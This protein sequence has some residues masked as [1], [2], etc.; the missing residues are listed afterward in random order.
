MNGHGEIA[1]GV[2]L[3]N[4]VREF[5]PHDLGDLLG[6]HL[7]SREFHLSELDSH[8]LLIFN[9]T[10]RMENIHQHCPSAWVT[11]GPVKINLDYS[12]PENT[13]HIPQDK[14]LCAR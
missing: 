5:D 14:L 6:E 10:Y 1:R 7:N 9:L 4:R 8:L 12:F 13:V 11:K 2:K 3:S